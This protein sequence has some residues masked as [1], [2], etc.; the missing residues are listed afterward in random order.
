MKNIPKL[1]DLTLEEINESLI[2]EIIKLIS[3]KREFVITPLSVLG[4]TGFPIANQ[5]D[6]LNN[7]AKTRKIKQILFDLS[8]K[9]FIEQRK[10]QQ[11]YKGIKE[12]GYNFIKD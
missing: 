6:V 4:I 7:K 3:I 11:D 9:G 10:S 12:I 1:Y 5:I 2:L 8:N